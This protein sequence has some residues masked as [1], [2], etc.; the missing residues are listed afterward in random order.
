MI[1]TLQRD[2][3]QLLLLAAQRSLYN[4][5]KHLYGAYATLLAVLFIL[6]YLCLI[7]GCSNTY[8]VVFK[9][10]GTSLVLIDAFIV[11][12]WRDNWQRKAAVI[13][14]EYDCTVLG[15][16]WNDLKVGEKT[17]LHD[18][19]LQGKN[20]KNATDTSWYPWE[21]EGI[22]WT[23]QSVF[24]Q[25]AIC[26]W[27]RD[28][29]K[30]TQLGLGT[31]LSVILLAAF[32]VAYIINPTF[33][34]MFLTGIAVLPHILFARR[35]YV[36]HA[37]SAGRYSQLSKYADETIEL[38]FTTTGSEVIQRR[39]R[40][41]QDMIFEMRQLRP[42]VPNFLYHLKRS[43]NEQMM[44]KRATLFVNRVKGLQL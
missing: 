36:E 27:N 1:E 32:V 38:L 44:R 30:S 40:C 6:L 42:L 3:K 10:V 12:P 33:K 20:N 8:D 5:A 21:L 26:I 15:I 22:P 37:T 2:G 34:T 18:V 17:Q 25:Q 43:E 41:L 16:P 11:I 13:Q 9:I 31:I 19:L 7:A 4:K 28:Q 39:Q 29:H 14:E 23:Y 24:C 35:Y